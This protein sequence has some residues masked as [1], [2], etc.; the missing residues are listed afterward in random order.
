M[1]ANLYERFLEA[2]I[3][4]WEHADQGSRQYQQAN[5]DMWSAI[6]DAVSEHRSK[7]TQIP[8]EVAFVLEHE[9]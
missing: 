7:G 3:R 8:Q 2:R 4:M 6:L 9:L 1:T 5:A